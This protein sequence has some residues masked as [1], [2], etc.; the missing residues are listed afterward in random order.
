MW[1]EPDVAQKSLTGL[2]MGLFIQT[3]SLYNTDL[4]RQSQPNET[5]AKLIVHICARERLRSVYAERMLTQEQN[6]TL[7]KA[8]QLLIVFSVKYCMSV[9]FNAPV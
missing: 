3:F 6:A 8:L 5:Q 9:L 1:Y 4:Q 2:D 7:L